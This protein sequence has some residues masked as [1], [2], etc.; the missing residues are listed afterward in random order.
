MRARIYV[1]GCVCEEKEEM[2]GLGCYCTNLTRH[3]PLSLGRL[4]PLIQITS[5]TFIILDLTA[6]DS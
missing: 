3:N 5:I 4:E 1:C 2:I 6:A